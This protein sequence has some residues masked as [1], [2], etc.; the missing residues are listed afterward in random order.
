METHETPFS[1]YAVSVEG[2]IVNEEGKTLEQVYTWLC[3]EL[4]K[5]NAPDDKWSVGPMDEYFSNM[6]RHYPSR[7]W[8]ADYNWIACFAV[9]GGSEGHY[10]HVESITGDKRDLLFLGKT[11][12]GM[13][14]A[15]EA[16]ALLTN[17]LQC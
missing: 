11:F 9:T 12:G 4:R 16:V 14:Q 6:Q 3:G 15:L 10:V 2:A 5:H 13:E 8:P 1:T 7:K 17:I